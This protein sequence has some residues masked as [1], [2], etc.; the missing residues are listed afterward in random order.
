M[1][2]AL[3]LHFQCLLRQIMRAEVEGAGDLGFEPLGH[4][5]VGDHL[6]GGGS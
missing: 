6:E 3:D 1:Q 4:E 5:R 2:E